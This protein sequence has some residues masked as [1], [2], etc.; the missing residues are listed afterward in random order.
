MTY[1]RRLP[2]AGSPTA[3]ELLSPRWTVPDHKRS[4]WWLGADESTVPGHLYRGDVGGGCIA[5]GKNRVDIDGDGF[6]DVTS[7]KDTMKRFHNAMDGDKYAVLVV[8]NI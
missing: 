7:S 1:D 3:M 8:R 6:K 4:D 2:C 5:L